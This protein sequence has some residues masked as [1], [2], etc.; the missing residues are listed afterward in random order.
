MKPRI[1]ATLLSDFYSCGLKAFHHTRHRPDQRDRPGM[2]N[3]AII[4]A[5]NEYEKEIL[6]EFQPVKIEY[7]PGNYKEAFEKTRAEMEKGSEAIYHGILYDEDDEFEYVCEPDLLHMGKNFKNNKKFNAYFIS[8][9]KKS[10]TVKSHHVVQLCFNVFL[11]KKFQKD[12]SGHQFIIHSKKRVPFY[13][14]DY[15]YFFYNLL[16]ALKKTI[17]SNTPPVFTSKIICANCQWKTVCFNHAK[18][19][20]Q[21]GMIHSLTEKE[22]VLL[23][24]I[25]IKKLTDISPKEKEL[26]NYH[27]IYEK[28]RAIILSR[29]AALLN[30]RDDPIDTN[31]KLSPNPILIHIEKDLVQSKDIL[32][33]I[34]YDIYQKN[35]EFKFSPDPGEVVNSLIKKLNDIPMEKLILTQEVMLKYLK[36]AIILPNRIG[37]PLSIQKMSSLESLIGFKFSLNAILYDFYS[38]CHHFKLLNKDEEPL[39]VYLK[40]G[41]DARFKE[42]LKRVILAGKELLNKI[43]A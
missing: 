22:I 10:L 30:D 26:K 33:Y 5:G 34:T 8:E 1:T 20:R 6:K 27:Y 12:I 18:K 35:I 29:S 11:L 38:L 36:E 32:A 13:F 4:V 43:S 7:E 42:S 24:K 3:Q 25:G 39:L 19:N 40:N 17:K 28:R 16:E 2:L 9:I 31:L 14:A 37:N 23:N 21:L 41:S 15:E